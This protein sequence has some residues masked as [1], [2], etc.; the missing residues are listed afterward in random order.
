MK[1]EKLILK[2]KINQLFLDGE[3]ILICPLFNNID[4]V[5]PKSYSSWHLVSSNEQKLLYYFKN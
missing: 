4:L 1:I 2:A 3:I 5:E